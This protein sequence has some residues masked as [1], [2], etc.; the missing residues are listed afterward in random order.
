M[1]ALE[2]DTYKKKIIEATLTGQGG[3]TAKVNKIIFF[4]EEIFT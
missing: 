2:V 4:F 3:T 1:A